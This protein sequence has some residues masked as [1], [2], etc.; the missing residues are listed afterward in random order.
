M[1]QI[2]PFGYGDNAGASGFLRESQRA[3]AGVLANCGMAVTM[4]IGD[5]KD[6]HPS[7]K[8]DVGHRLALLAL[9][10]TYGRQ[11]LECCGPTLSKAAVEAGAIRVW[12]T[13]AAGLVARGGA[14]AQFR[15]A[16][17]DGKF[18]AADARVDGETVV[19]TSPRVKQP[20]FV[21]YAWCEDC[22]VNLF[23][24]AG[25]PAGPFRT[26]SFER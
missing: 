24:A 7:N 23:N 8:Q 1:V 6:I 15:L 9:A 13:H 4:D 3:T 2:A 19:L 5:A 17:E 16:G 25:L 12:F 20:L 14:P 10:R 22:A 21:R 18:E 26:D 11:E